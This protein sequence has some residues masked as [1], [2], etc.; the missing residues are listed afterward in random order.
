MEEKKKTSVKKV[1]EKPKKESMRHKHM[2]KN[3]WFVSTLVLVVVLVLGLVLIFAHVGNKAVSE[4]KA[5]SIIQS[6]VQAQAQNAQVTTIVKGPSFYEANVSVDGQDAGEIYLTYDGKN[7]VIPAGVL[8][9]SSYANAAPQQNTNSGSTA[10]TSTIPKTAKPTVELFV[11]SYCP[12]GTQEEK[13]IL[14][15]VNALGNNINFS[16]KFVDY[17]MHGEKEVKENLRQYCIEK[18][19]PQKFLNYLTCFLDGNGVVGQSGY[20]EEGNNPNTCIVQSGIDNNTLNSCIAQ[21]DKEYSIMAN[22]KDK[23]TWL[24]GTY[25]PFNTDKALN[26]KYGVQGSPTLVINGVQ[27]NSARDPASILSTICSAFSDGNVPSACSTQLSTETPTVY[28]GW[29]AT[30]SA[31]SGSNAQCG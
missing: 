10:S 5:E 18:T 13:G 6:F 7:V 16:I 2:K 29:N 14:P 8:D 22:F 26:Q 19:Q 3:P 15:A 21:T 24:S 25:P 31:S 20:V 11:M 12:Y 17:A 28:F 23:S 9:V 27:A 1:D 30:A 4:K